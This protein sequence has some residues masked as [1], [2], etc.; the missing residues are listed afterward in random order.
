MLPK[1]KDDKDV[2]T[3]TGPAS[4]VIARVE[5]AIGRV[6]GANDVAEA[7]SEVRSC[8]IVMAFVVKATLDHV[9]IFRFFV[10]TVSPSFGGLVII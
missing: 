3:A 9:L 8:G 7:I 4:T 5:S 1:S 10:K 2:D 6:T